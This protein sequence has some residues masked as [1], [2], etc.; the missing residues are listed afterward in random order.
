MIIS[1]KDKET[2]KIYNQEVSTK[3][4]SEI[5]KSALRKLILICTHFL[6]QK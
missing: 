3:I 1:F 6:G 4:P 2:E 5:Q